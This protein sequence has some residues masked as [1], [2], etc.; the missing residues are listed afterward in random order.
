MALA[1]VFPPLILH[2]NTVE[3]GAA[4]A[5]GKGLLAAVYAVALASSLFLLLVAAGAVEGAAWITFPAAPLLLVA[6]I[7]VAAATGVRR[8]SGAP[9]ASGEKP[10][11][12]YRPFILLAAVALLVLISSVLVMGRLAA[13]AER[14]S[15]G[16][17][18]SAAGSGAIMGIGRRS[19]WRATRRRDGPSPP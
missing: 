8:P 11:R 10:P 3:S 13:A 2:G 6:L 1:F 17:T 14:L 4:G 5:T 9:A 16:W 19:P 12:R 15:V 18:T 7:A